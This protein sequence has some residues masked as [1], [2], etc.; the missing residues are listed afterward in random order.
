MSSFSLGSAAS[1]KDDAWLNRLLAANPEQRKEVSP[2]LEMV[3]TSDKLLREQ[4][5][6]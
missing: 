2:S 5:G 6:V 1:L 3:D 4:E